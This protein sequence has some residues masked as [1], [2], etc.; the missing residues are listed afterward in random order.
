MILLEHLTTAEAV[1]YAICVIAVIILFGWIVYC[2]T[3][4]KK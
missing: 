4:Y 3:K 2:G 1:S